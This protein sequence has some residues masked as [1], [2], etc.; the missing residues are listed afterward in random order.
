MVS[1]GVLP[2]ALACAHGAI[3]SYDLTRRGNATIP[4]LRKIAI[5]DVRVFDGFKLELPRRVIIDHGYISDDPF[6]IEEVVQGN[7]RVLIPGLMDS[8]LHTTSVS[9]L[10]DLSSYGVTTAFNMNCYNYTACDILRDQPG[11]TSAF[12]ASIP[13]V[14]PGSNHER[15]LH[16]P[17]SLLVNPSSQAPEVVSWA[18][19]NNS[20]YY[21]I[22]SEP[23]GCDQETQ[24]A[25]VEAVHQRG[26]KVMTHGSYLDYFQ[27]AVKSGS[28]GLQ[29][30]AA[31]GLVP[32]S[33]IQQI[34]AQG[35]YV[36]PMLNI[37]YQTLKNVSTI[38]FFD[39]RANY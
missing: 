38:E 30:T 29:H 18:F 13:A 21:K 35:Q 24:N 14:G 16:L 15:M 34:R 22:V 32:D 19:G 36:T 33:I 26:K 7:G 27:M 37:F 8:H 12:Y 23:N 2:S 25:L 3:P 20:D 6:G 10:E 28:D 31:D 9:D 5:K 1:L 17:D 11:L 39:R 4:P